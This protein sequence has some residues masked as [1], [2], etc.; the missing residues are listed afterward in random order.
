MRQAYYGICAYS[1]QWICSVTGVDTVDHFVPK[2]T[3]PD[4]AYEWS[5]Y[6][7]SSLKLNSRKGE[8]SILDP[9]KIGAGW[10]VLTFPALLVKPNPDLG[11][12]LQEAV[13]N[14][15]RVLKLNDDDT[16]VQSRQTWLLAFCHGEIT[17]AHLESKAPF[18]AYELVRQNLVVVIPEIMGVK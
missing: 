4:L 7:Y 2:S 10:F 18:V 6:R 9:F 5:N 17:F 8:R 11:D 15:I 16:C 14:T 13:H 3:R 1:A 12:E